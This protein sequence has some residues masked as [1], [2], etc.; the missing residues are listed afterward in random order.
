MTKRFFLVICVF[1]FSY[2]AVAQ[3]KVMPLPV[4][5]GTVLGGDYFFYALPKTAF[6]VDVV[7]ERNREV[8][9][10]YSEYASKLLGL[11]HSIAQNKTSYSL[12]SVSLR[13]VTVLDEGHQYAVELSANQQKQHY[14]ST[15]Y[16]N[17]MVAAADTSVCSSYVVSESSIPDFY[18]YYSDLSYA[19]LENSYVETQI[20]DG[21]VRQ[22]PASHVQKVTKSNEQKAQEAADMVAKI[23]TDR[24]ELLTGSQEVAYEAAALEMM[25]SKLDELEKNY[26]GLFTGF[27]VTEEIHYSFT[28]VPSRANT[29]IPAFSVSPTTGFAAVGGSSNDTYYLYL[30]PQYSNDN[31]NKFMAEREKG[32]KYQAPQGYRIRRPVPTEV[33]LDY[34]NKEVYS[35]G[36]HDVYQFGKVETLPQGNDDF[37]ISKF[38]ILY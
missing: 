30:T 8:K 16:D 11:T 28:I 3:Q 15:L 17:A 27:T 35:F 20:V 37:D 10:I 7:V 31:W 12:K 25:I 2:V 29:L 34:Q 22:V 5:S 26:L 13:D 21:V 23:R 32:K 14:L 19:E 24:Y 36:N 18:R 9:G 1:F 38:V 33:S 4:D 6:Q